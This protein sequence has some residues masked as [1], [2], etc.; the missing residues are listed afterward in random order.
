MWCSSTRTIRQLA[1]AIVIATFTIM[2]TAPAN[3]VALPTQRQV[4]D[5]VQ[6]APG[7]TDSAARATPTRQSPVPAGSRTSTSLTAST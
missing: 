1:R 4:S 5:V 2:I 3:V 6:L 7:V